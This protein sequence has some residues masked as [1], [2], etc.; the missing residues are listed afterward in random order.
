MDNLYVHKTKE[1]KELYE[2]LKI[3]P[4]YNVPYSP[5]TN[6]IEACFSIVKNYYNRKRLNCLVNN[7]DFDRDATID[8]AF[9]QVRVWHVKKSVAHSLQALHELKF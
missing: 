4:L 7:T 3:T 5:E 8:E 9:G 2:T 1:V 6:P